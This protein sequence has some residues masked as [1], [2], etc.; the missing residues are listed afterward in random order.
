MLC[1]PYSKNYIQ[2]YKVYQNNRIVVPLHLRDKYSAQLG[3]EFYR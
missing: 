3:N 2:F 1:L